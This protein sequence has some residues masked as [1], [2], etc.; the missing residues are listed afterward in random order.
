MK[1]FF[2]HRILTFKNAQKYYNLII[3]TIVIYCIYYRKNFSCE[4]RHL[5]RLCCM[6]SAVHQANNFLLRIA[7]ADVILFPLYLFFSLYFGFFVFQKVLPLPP[8][9]KIH[10]SMVVENANSYILHLNKINKIDNTLIHKLF[11]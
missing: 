6:Y 3:K 8:L 2:F 9:G 4:R 1:Y 7:I 5:H 10:L 11:E